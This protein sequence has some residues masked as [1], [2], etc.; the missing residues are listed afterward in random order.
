MSEP[1]T[2]AGQPVD[3]EKLAEV[4]AAVQENQQ[5]REKLDKKRAKLLEKRTALESDRAKH[6]IDHGK[7][8]KG[9]AEKRKSA[10]DELA[11]TNRL[12]EAV[13]AAIQFEAGQGEGLNATLVQMEAQLE[14]DR[15]RKIQESIAE[16]LS[17]AKEEFI[18]LFTEC[19]TKLGEV[20]RLGDRLVAAEG[21]PL[22]NE[23]LDDI[24]IRSHRT[25]LIDRF[26][27][28]EPQSGLGLARREFVVTALNPPPEQVDAKTPA[29]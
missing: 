19:C 21:L 28:T 13:D 2:G 27:F 4:R 18:D 1:L 26:K 20:V 3:P 23:V 8:I 14:L 22:L 16:E 17:E 11:E 12:I 7:G 6:L 5:E 15:K 29:A 10:E 25:V 24:L 9:A